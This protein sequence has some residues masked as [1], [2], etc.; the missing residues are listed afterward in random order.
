[1]STPP[2]RVLTACCVAHAVQDGF[3]AVVTTLLPVLAQAFGLGYAQVGA[4][5]A[6]HAVALSAFEIPS[7]LMSERLGARPLLIGGLALGGLGFL[8]LAFATGYWSVLLALV[9]A[10]VGA[11]FQHTLASA[12]ITE[13][14][15][16]A[17]RRTALG[18][19]N[20]VGDLG[21]LG[22]AALFAVMV[23]LGIGWPVVAAGLGVCGLAAALVLRALL[24]G[25]S[26]PTSSTAAPKAPIRGWGIRDR[27]GFAALT[28][29][30]LLDSIVQSG[31]LTFVAFLMIEKGVSAGLAAFAV[32]LTLAGGAAGKF[33]CGLLAEKLGVVRTFVI[34]QLLTVVG[35]LAV[36]ALPALAAFAV[37]PLLGVVLQ[38]S[39]SPTYGTVGD[40]IT[41]ERQARGFGLIYTVANG[42]AIAPVFLGVLADWN[43]VEAAMWAMIVVTLVSVPLCVP[44]A[45]ALRSA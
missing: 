5:K 6:V 23:G 13:A 36:M 28:T 42:S 41:P 7:G 21:K 31:F 8:C 38:G 11:G 22:F 29:I 4:I 24:R 10:G 2:G 18:T 43:G 45:R 25:S 16:G 33:A 27:G 17:G 32:V 35:I 3:V 12:M 15:P 40:L 39:T 44:L 37:L 9:A 14:W 26:A 1:M 34:A 19:Y 30:I 20:A